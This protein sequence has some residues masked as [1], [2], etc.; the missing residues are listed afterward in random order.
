[1][2]KIQENL[3]DQT[4][5]LRRSEERYL[6]MIDEIHDY[7]VLL[8]DMQGTI[9]N[10]NKGAEKLKGY[11]ADEIVGRNFRL[12][13]RD[14]EQRLHLP[15]K[16]LK[17]AALK[18]RAFHEGWR[19]RKDGSL[20]WASVVITA[21]HDENKEVYAF[22]KITK[23]LTE[24]KLS[25]DRLRRYIDDLTARNQQLKQTEERYHRLVDEV[26]DYAIF[27]MSVEGNIETWNKGAEKIKGY[28][29]DEII[30]KNF[31][32]FFPPESLEQGLP[33]RLLQEAREAGRAVHEGWRVRKNGNKFWGAI[34]ITALHNEKNEVI[35]FTKV[36]RDLTQRKLAE[37]ALKDTAA[38]LQKN[39]EELRRSEERYYR[40]IDEVQDYAILLLDKEGII[41]NWNKGAEKI[42]GYSADEIIGKSFIIFYTEEDQR[43]GLPMQL[44]VEA[45][46]SG[47]SAHEGWRVRKDG[48]IFWGSMVLTALHDRNNNLIGFSKVTRDL[49]EKKLAEDSLKQHTIRLEQTN[50]ELEQFAYVA[51]HDLKEPL[52]K[53]L[54]FG[55]LLEG[56]Y[57]E[58]MDE[59]GKEYIKRMQ[60]AAMRM[61]SLIEDLLVFSRVNRP[62]EEFELVDLNVVIDRVLNDLEV[63]VNAK[64]ARISIDKLP[65]VKGRKSQLGQLFQNL[66]SNALKFNDKDIPAL[67]IR[68]EITGQ[69]NPGSVNIFVTDNGIGFDMAYSGRIFEIF[70]RLHGKTE[71][72][73]TGIGLA[74]CKKIVEAHGGTISA[75]AIPDQGST[76]TITLPLP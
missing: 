12:F 2:L 41:Q 65:K 57:K 62:S 10:W 25:E 3:P 71:Y 60:N 76:F 50:E 51:S 27:R 1:M 15:E 59:K 39:L 64:K 46:Q 73:G 28:S 43:S 5:A 6:R 26:Q 37:D 35:G 11:K 23:D 74:I 16:L 56:N 55:N 4:E 19:I 17:E 38:R 66:I 14:E 61:M 42:K 20:F 45:E 49:T 34:V 13:Y 7:A 40:M 58:V 18:G 67:T 44:L 75:T 47:R 68:C 31:K 24:Q 36:T 53:I 52:R 33:Q 63:Q 70:Q 48:S 22:L 72:P 30:G 21:L 54:T 9:L 32:I 8:L 29:A 69:L